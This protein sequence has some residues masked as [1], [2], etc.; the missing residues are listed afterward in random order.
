[1]PASSR[2]LRTEAPNSTGRRL[3][4]I[5][6]TDQTPSCTS[7]TPTTSTTSASGTSTAAAAGQA[8]QPQRRHEVAAGRHLRVPGATARQPLEHQ[9]RE[10]H[11][12]EQRGE[13]HGRV[14]V[15]RLEPDAVDRVG[16]GADAEQVDGA[17]VGERLHQRERH[18][19]EDRRPRQRD[20]DPQDRPRARH[21]EPARRLDQ[22]ARLAQERGARQQIHVRVEHERE[23]HDGAARRADARNPEAEREQREHVARHGER[24]HERPL[25]P[26]PALGTRR[27]RRARRARCRARACHHPLRSGSRTWRPP[28]PAGSRRTGRSRPAR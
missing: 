17:E 13:L 18:A 22:R 5:D 2:L 20:P 25:D 14:A 11:G 16:E 7:G 19:A 24:Q 3:S 1:M 12:H 9:E 28:P 15:E 26:P 10:R 27:T 21:A 6:C 4:R 8:A 23:H